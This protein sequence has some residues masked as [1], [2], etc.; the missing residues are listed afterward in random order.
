MIPIKQRGAILLLM[1]FVVMVGA[2]TAI[3]TQLNQKSSAI[4]RDIKSTAALNSAKEALIGWAL[5]HTNTGELPLPDTDNDAQGDCPATVLDTDRVGRLPWLNYPAPCNNP[6]SG[7]GMN[8]KD[9]NGE[10]LWYAVSANLIDDGTTPPVIDATML[11]L[12]SGW[13]SVFD[14]AGA[15][16]SDRAAAVIIA[17]GKSLSGQNRTNKNSINAYLESMNS[18]VDDQFIVAVQQ[19]DF[20]DR[21]IY[22]TV[23]ELLNNSVKKVIE[24]R[25]GIW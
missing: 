3:V 17:P 18:I 4:K 25:G 19:E 16:L 14:E 13:L 8:F 21:L 24:G 9:Q 22:I 12:N 2:M 10:T 6:R 20:N 15:L 23:D 11:L 7:I 5:T 1:M